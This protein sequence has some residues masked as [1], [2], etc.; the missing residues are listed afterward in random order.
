M[1][2]IPVGKLFEEG[3]VPLILKEKKKDSA[4]RIAQSQEHKRMDLLQCNLYRNERDSPENNGEQSSPG[5]DFS[6]FPMS[7]SFTTNQLKFHQSIAGSNTPIE[8]KKIPI[9]RVDEFGLNVQLSDLFSHLFRQTIFYLISFPLTMGEGW[10][11][12]GRLG[13]SPPT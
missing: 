9:F 13:P 11:G 10:D 8:P 6:P 1:D 3:F 7:P 2:P 4:N 12:G 5:Q